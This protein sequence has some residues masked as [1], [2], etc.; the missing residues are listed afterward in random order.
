MKTQPKKTVK[1]LCHFLRFF[2]NLSGIS[3]LLITAHP[4]NTKIWSE[5]AILLDGAGWVFFSL[6][7]IESYNINL[8]CLKAVKLEREVLIVKNNVHTTV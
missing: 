5:L 7:V 8:A 6:K 3:W 2:L 4:C 1:E